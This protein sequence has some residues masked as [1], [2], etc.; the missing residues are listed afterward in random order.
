MVAVDVPAAVVEV[1]GSE[2]VMAVV[3]GGLHP[4]HSCRQSL[5]WRHLL[6]FHLCHPGSLSSWF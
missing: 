2:S 5:M 6:M 1:E 3:A 4:S